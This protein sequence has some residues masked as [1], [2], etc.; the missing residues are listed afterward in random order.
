MKVFTAVYD[1]DYDSTHI[2]GVFTTHDLAKEHLDKN[3][4]GWGDQ[5]YIQEWELDVGG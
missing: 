2:V 4:K 5:Q 1:Y 3:Y